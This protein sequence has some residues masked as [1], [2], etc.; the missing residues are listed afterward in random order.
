M[1]ISERIEAAVARGAWPTVKEAKAE[2]AAHRKAE[3][4]PGGFYVP[5]LTHPNGNAKLNKSVLPTY[6]LSLSPARTSGYNLCPNSTPLCRKGCLSTAGRAQYMPRINQ[7]REVK[8]RFLVRNPKAFLVLLENELRLAV[9]RDGYILCR[10]N[11][12]SDLEWERFA[13]QLFNIGGVDYYDYTKNHK[14]MAR[15]TRG[16]FPVNYKLVRSISERDSDD[17]VAD[18]LAAGQ[19]AVMV[20][21][22][23]PKTWHG[24]KVVNGDLSD[25]RFS[26]PDGVL[27]GLKAKGKMRDTAQYVPFIRKT[28]AKR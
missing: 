26:E 15:Y 3:G 17:H 7:R 22:R 19:T 16:E 1:N 18:I 8:A 10:L 5:L 2:W 14:R 12:L 13:P 23:V 25:D 20:F 24:I 4:L 21:D 28:G 11:V 27:V 9:K 6:G